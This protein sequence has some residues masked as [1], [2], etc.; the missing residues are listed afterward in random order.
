[1]IYKRKE[2]EE[3]RNGINYYPLNDNNS[4]GFIVK[5]FRIIWRVRYSLNAKKW[6]FTLRYIDPNALEKLKTWEAKHGIKHE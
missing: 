3:I 4:H 2:G 1:M 6:F 5:V